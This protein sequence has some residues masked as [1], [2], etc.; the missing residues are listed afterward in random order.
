MVEKINCGIYVRVSTDKQD[1]S[2]ENQVGQA[3]EFISRL[4]EGYVLDEDSIFVDNTVS[5]YFTSVF[6]R[7]AMKQ[8]IAKAKAG[9]LQVLVFKAITRVGRDKQENPAI[10]GMFEQYGVRVIAINDNYDSLNKDSITFDILSVL[11]EQESKKT[12][13]SVSSARKVKASRGEWGGE[14]PIGYIKDKATQKLVPDPDLKHIPKLIFEL[15]SSGEMG[16][17]KIAEHLNERGMFTKN[18]RYWSRGTVTNVL[19]NEAYMGDVVH[20]KRKNKLERDYDDSGRMTKRKVQIKT[21]P[22]EWTIKRGA[23]KPL[24]DPEVFYTAQS[25]LGS[26][27]VHR[28]ARRAY[29]PLTGILYCS[30]CGA[31]MVC[32]KR[33]YKET[34]YRYYICKT[35]HKYGR[36]RC[37]QANINADELEMTIVDIVRRRLNE[38]STS[39]VVASAN[40]DDDVNRLLKEQRRVLL[41]KEQAERDQVD[42]FNQRE[43]FTDDVYKEQMIRLKNQIKTSDEELALVNSQIEV[44]NLQL[45]E[46]ANITNIIEQFLKLDIEEKDTATLRALL[47]DLIDNIKAS[48]DHLDIEYNYD[49][50]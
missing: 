19:K 29:H 13:V 23:H 8:A 47:H 31:G 43:L 26:R 49:L 33:S 27:R 5:G 6:E 1:T 18:N 17:F 11:A 44:I 20:G 15:Y 32:Q 4:G 50:I 40:R 45:N 7:E 25:I 41:A 2:V 10:V 34:E 48:E 21:D 14:A 36:A 16:T 3:E 28:K 39:K 37:S 12:S 30:Q 24:V 38:L 42:T 46:S 35:Y 22:S 9:Q